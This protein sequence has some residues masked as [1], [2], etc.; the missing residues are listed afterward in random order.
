MKTHLL[1]SVVLAACLSIGAKAQTNN[2]SYTIDSLANFNTTQWT[3]FYY[4]HHNNPS[5]L[6]E[7]LTAQK[8]DYIY[9]TYFSTNNRLLGQPNTPQQACTNMDFENGSLSGWNTTTGFHPSYNPLGCCQSAGGAQLITTGAGNDPCAGFPVV[10][11]GGSFSVR[12]GNNGVGGVADR[13]EQTFNVTAANANFTYKYAVVFQDPGHA[14]N[15]QPSF[16]IQM[17]DSNGLQIPCTYYNVAAGQNIPGFISSTNC[18]NVVYKPWSSV[19][20]DLTSYIGQ[21]VTVQFTTYDCALGGHYAYAYL[22]GSCTNFNFTQSAPLCQGS[23]IQLSGPTGFANY[24]WTLPNNTTATGQTITTGL[25]GQYILNLTTV[26]GCPGPTLTYTLVSFPSPNAAFNQIVNSTCSQTV[27][28]NNSSNISSGSIS[29]Y[30][31]NF[32][33]GA[34]SVNPNPTITYN[35]AGNYNVQLIC[36]SNMGCKDTMALPITIYAQPLV[37]FSANT[38]CANAITNFVNTSSVATGSIVSNAWSFGDGQTA[39]ISQPNHQYAT[40]GNY[41][42]TLT[43]LTNGNCSN[44]ISHVV[45]VNPLPTI[46][47]SANNVCQGN[48][49][50]YLNTSSISSGSI[51]NFIWDFTNDGIADNTNTNT[52]T[53]FATNG[54]YITKLTAISNNNCIT[55]YTQNVIVYPNPIALFSSQ[56]VCEGLNTSFINQSSISSGLITSS[57]WLFGD[58]SNSS[59]VNPQHLYSSAGNY[60][61]QLTVTSNHNCVTII[62]QLAIVHPKPNVQFQSSIACLNQA[63]QF[64]NQTT[65]SAGT[66]SIYRWDFD[67]NNTIDDSTLNPSF[68]YPNA[69]LMPCRL[70]ALSNNNCANQIINQV[71]IHANP[72]ANFSVPSA[73]MPNTSSFTNLSS[74]SDGLITS[75]GWDFN[76]DNIIDNVL[77]NPTY[78]FAQVG[79]HAVKLEIQTQYGC[80]NTLIKSAYVNATPT[81]LFSA[82]NNIGCPS[83]CVNFTHSCTIGNGNITTYQW[84]F[85]DNSSPDYSQN[86][87]HC[88]GTGLYNV[89]LKAVSDSGCIASYS[90]PNLVTVYP[91]PIANFNVTPSEV[92]ITTPLIEVEDKSTGASS[93]KYKFSDGTIKNTANFTHLFTTDI[94]KTVFIMQNVVNSYGCR[95]SIIKQIDIKPS[96][97][98]Y[99]PNA[100]SPNSDGIN[101]G[102][103][104]LGVGIEQFKLQIF[105]R[106]GALIFESNDI[107]R[108]WDGSV[109]G[110][111]NSETTK[112]EVYVW[113]AE[114]T[115][116]LKQHHDL[117]GHVTLLK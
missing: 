103:K 21:N 39:G 91:T 1:T 54:T 81:I 94:A 98:L 43:V 106:W 112:E 37:A 109:N 58:G 61:V 79:N 31:W 42:V 90:Q 25:P 65:I 78:N 40:S 64:N 49:T 87:T 8:R 107:N 104:A 7:F 24:I 5:E 67:N 108:A 57:N 83:L 92:D 13:L 66:I 56:A 96:Y 45:T 100:F 95:D 28:F 69:G 68:V 105:D 114:V 26:T 9:H 74:S 17:L 117:I 22:D 75:Y 35:T 41:N 48:P 14:I 60:N 82:K 102:F 20:V 51:S 46:V 89:S 10:A 29:S 23:T 30:Q 116:V 36:T 72:T 44:T 73:C 4:Q 19:S 16:Q 3:N 97:V 47:F 110:K 52:S 32:G 115:D 93:V 2:S 15:D 18:A 53:L 80:T 76:G 27:S 85:G 88:Y 63:S 11:P 12:L 86:P 50:N 33:N 62:S 59:I 71:T 84:V 111:G 55:S 6:T 113:K 34:S 99:I 38:V 101:D 77:A 70:V